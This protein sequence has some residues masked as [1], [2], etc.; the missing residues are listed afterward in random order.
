MPR[1]TRPSGQRKQTHLRIVDDTQ[2]TLPVPASFASLSG[3]VPRETILALEDA[4]RRE[5]DY[6]ENFDD[7]LTHHYAPGAYA[8]EMLLRKGSIVVG[9]IHKHAH[10]NVVSKGDVLVVTEDGL[11]RITAPSTF[12]SKP[13]TKRAVYALEESIWTTVHVTEKTDLVEIEEEM[14]YK[15]YAQLDSDKGRLL[16]QKQ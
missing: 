15:N 7:V 9:K 2:E 4:I 8:R 10:I 6:Y 1:L 13:G 16:E 11:K 12:V 3:P 5:L 14:I